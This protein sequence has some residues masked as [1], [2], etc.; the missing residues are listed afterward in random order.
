[1]SISVSTAA[2]SLSGLTPVTVTFTNSEASD[3]DVILYAAAMD[4]KSP[5]G[6]PNAQGGEAVTEQWLEVSDDDG[7]NWHAL[8]FPATF[9]DTF[10]ALSSNCYTITVPASGTLDV[11]LRYNIAADA[12]SSGI[13]N[14]LLMWRYA[15]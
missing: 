8:G 11:L 5:A 10:E 7:A 2:A 13:I 12:A 14:Q 4:N 1:M 6:V 15:P 9:T 3:K